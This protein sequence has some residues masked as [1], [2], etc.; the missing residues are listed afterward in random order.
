MDQPD[1]CKPAGDQSYLCDYD[2]VQNRIMRRFLVKP[3]FMEVNDSKLEA[4]PSHSCDRL[5][6]EQSSDAAQPQEPPLFFSFFL[7]KA[8]TITHNATGPTDHGVLGVC[9]RSGQLTSF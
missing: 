2:Y 5:T 3:A 1:V 6:V 4:S 9:A 7:V 8:S